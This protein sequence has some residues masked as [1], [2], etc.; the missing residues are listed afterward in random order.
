MGERADYGPYQAAARAGL[1]RSEWKRAVE[2][3][4][5]LGPRSTGRWTSAAV[6]YARRRRAWIRTELQ[7][8]AARRYEWG[9]APAHLLTR[10]QLAEPGED[11][12]VPL[13]PGGP[14]RGV[15]RYYRHGWKQTYLY[16]VR[17][18][19]PKRALT[20]AQKAAIE[21]RKR[22]ARTCAGCHE[23]VDHPN[24][25]DSL[26]RC[27]SCVMTA[28]AKAWATA[29]RRDREEAAAWAREILDDPATVILDTETTGLNGYLVEIAVTD[30]RGQVLL[31]TLVNPVCEIEAGA[32]AVHGLT[33]DV[34]AGA[35]TYAE[36][37]ERLWSVL[38][39]RRVVIY[40]SAFDCD[41]ILFNEVLRAARALGPEPRD[42]V[43][44]Y[45]KPVRARSR[46]ECAME[47]YAAWFGAF[48]DYHGDYTWQPLGGGHRALADCH[49]VRERLIAMA[50]SLDCA[51]SS[52]DQG[53][54]L[55]VVDGA[56]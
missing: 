30:R 3:G 40:N 35:P 50:G 54:A 2:A 13:R 1:S 15:I 28:E 14:I 55:L 11:R 41:T 17:E 18:A 9:Q 52:V 48:D 21:E 47:M 20:D 36:L 29:R 34:L 45:W 16:D 56:S 4:L 23:V 38:N 46:W 53:E 33:L 42:A 39:G 26:R 51:Q 37:A 32:A 27:Y 7:V 43:A 6:E 44:R 31:D 49:A 10:A 25:L 24:E 12:P 8:E 5:V 19:V 22:Q